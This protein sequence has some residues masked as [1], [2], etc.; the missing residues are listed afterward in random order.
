VR[1]L[2]C[3]FCLPFLFFQN[4]FLAEFE[5]KFGS[6]SQWKQRG[7]ERKGREASY[8]N[9]ECSFVTCFY[10][11]IFPGVSADLLHQKE[12]TMH[13]ILPIRLSCFLLQRFLC[14]LLTSLILPESGRLISFFYWS[15]RVPLTN[16]EKYL[17]ALPQNRYPPST[18]I[19]RGGFC[20]PLA[21]PSICPVCDHSKSLMLAKRDSL[22]NACQHAVELSKPPLHTTWLPASEHSASTG[23]KPALLRD[24]RSPH[25][26]HKGAHYY[27]TSTLCSL[28][29]PENGMKVWLRD[30]RKRWK[31]KG[32][33]VFVR[34]ENNSLI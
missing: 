20:P 27:H 22:T 34:G 18:S 13:T 33:Y 23:G 6:G 28:H 4:L 19:P 8:N 25:W 3:I 9:K 31:W 16:A 29:H 14:P 10:K 26:I 12:K 30:A 21:V 15:Q 1:R 7:W 17:S 5:K 2:L 32:K 24:S 11:Y